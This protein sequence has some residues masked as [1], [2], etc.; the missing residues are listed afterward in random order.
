MN[1]NKTI[2]IGVA[3]V[4][5]IGALLFMVNAG[6]KKDYYHE[7]ADVPQQVTKLP[8]GMSN[9]VVDGQVVDEQELAKIVAAGPKPGTFKGPTAPPP[10]TSLGAGTSTSGITRASLAKHSV[11]TDCWVAFE[12]SVYDVTAFIP[13]HP[14]GADSI[15]GTCGMA[16]EFESAFIAQHGRSKVRMMMKVAPK[17]GTLAL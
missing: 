12:G 1:T 10:S 7:P 14:G 17:Q 9:A 4:V 8:D 11:A 6:E 15:T 5:L 16:E 3:A 2:G 13:K